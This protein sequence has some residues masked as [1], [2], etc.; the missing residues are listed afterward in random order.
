M[1]ISQYYNFIFKGEPEDIILVIKR[2]ATI[3]QLFKNYFEKIQKPNL[4]INNFDN[5]YFI[6]NGKM[7]NYKNENEETLESFFRNNLSS[8]F[9]VEVINDNLHYHNYKTTE[10]IKENI[11]SSVYKGEVDFI[12]KP[13]AIK[14]IS[15]EKIKEQIISE[16]M[17][18]EI[19]EDE[20]N[21]NIQKFNKE[22]ENMKKCEC[23]NSVT[24]YDYFETENE[25]III[26]ELCDETLFHLLCRKDNGFNSEEI[27]QIMLQLNNVFKKMNYY[28]ISHRDIKLNNILIKYLNNEKTKY[29][30]LLSDYGISTK[31]C[32]NS[33][34]FTSHEGTKLIMAPEI[35]KC[36]KYYNDKCDLWSIGV[37]MYQLYTKNFPYNPEQ[38]LDSILI[39]EIENKGQTILNDIDDKDKNLKS[40]L[41]ELLQ[42]DPQKRI[43]WDNYYKHPFF[44]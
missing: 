41:S 38:I 24:I 35:L 19:T 13:V 39:K 43:S 8:N 9:Y 17:K 30:V 36:D 10:L 20:L 31:K 7:M 1:N 42:T 16:K 6:I 5:I 14:K 15:K 25:F 22:V 26:M 4:Y 28:N 18:E 34:G 3:N 32:S 40:L 12:N 33:K 27:K 2:E 21:L 11:I 37:I 29:K 44:N 23:E